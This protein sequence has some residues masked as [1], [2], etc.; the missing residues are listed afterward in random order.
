MG[1]EIPRIALEESTYKREMHNGAAETRSNCSVDL[2]NPVI[3][4]KFRKPLKRQGYVFDIEN[5]PDDDDLSITGRSFR[6]VMEKAADVGAPLEESHLKAQFPRNYQHM[7][8]MDGPLK[9]AAPRVFS[10]RHVGF[11][12][13]FKH[14]VDIRR[15]G[16]MMD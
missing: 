14:K 6:S 12:Q 9:T 16:Y 4:R 8:I 3:K 13:L 1:G 2:A 15:P 7:D 5:A 11:T 10:K